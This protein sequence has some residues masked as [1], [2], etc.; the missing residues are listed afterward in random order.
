MLFL[1]SDWLNMV[2]YLLK[3]LG[4]NGI[5]PE[6]SAFD[7]VGQEGVLRP[8]FVKSCRRMLH[9]PSLHKVLR[10]LLKRLTRM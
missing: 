8:D 4:T 1:Q 3:K 2:R 7:T 5:P 9:L 6:P 10:E